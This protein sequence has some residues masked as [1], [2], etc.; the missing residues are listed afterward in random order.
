MKQDR[1]DKNPWEMVGRY[2][3]LAMLL[4]V[5]T[6]VGYAIGYL[7]DK[8]LGTTWLYLPCL[9]LGIVAGFVSL[10]RELQKDTNDQDAGR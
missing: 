6:F 9:L 3:S 4:P 7:L 5:S 1:R 10:L 8:W 2:T